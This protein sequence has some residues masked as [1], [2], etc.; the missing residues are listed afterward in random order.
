MSELMSELK[1]A[2]YIFALL[3]SFFTL[4]VGSAVEAAPRNGR[5]VE[6]AGSIER[7]GN[8]TDIRQRSDFLATRWDNFNIAAHESVQAHQPSSTSR[9]LIR[10]DGG[11]ATNIAG[12]YTSNG[13]TILENQ[14]GIQFSRGAIVNVGGLLATSSRISGVSGANWQLNGV[15][16]AVVNHGK[17]VAGAGGA[18]LAAV[19]VQNTGDIT[20]KGGDVALGAGSSFTVDFAG[21]MVGFEVTKAASGVSIVNTGKIESQGGVV[22]LSAQEAQAVRTNVV[23]VGGVVK[24]TKME[25]RGG[26]V[27]LSGGDEGVA[28]VSG[29]VQADE[30]IQMT[31]EYVV[32]KEDAVLTAPEI[33]VGGDFQGKGDVPTA[34]RTLVEA[35]ALLDAGQNGRIIVWS[36][37]TTWFNGRIF[38]PEGFAEVSGKEVLASVNLAGID[39][40]ELLL[41]PEHIG[42]TDSAFFINA[43]VTGNV[44]ADAPTPGGVPTLW[45]DVASVNRFTGNLSLEA[46]TSFSVSFGVTINKPV[47]NLTLIA[48]GDMRI[49]GSINNHA[50]TLTLI[51]GVRLGGEILGFS[52][53][54]TLTASTV[55]LMQNGA[56]SQNAQFTFAADTLSL[57]IT[58][59]AQTVQDWMTSGNRALSLTASGTITINSDVNTGTGALSLTAGEGSETGNLVAC[60]T[61]TLTAGTLALTQADAFGS[62]APFIFD[63]DTL[64]LTTT[65]AAQ[66]V[67]GWMAASGRNLS[68]ISNAA[69]TINE[70]ISIGSGNLT[71][72]GREGIVLGGSVILTAKEVELIG[73]MNTSIDNSDLTITALS[74]VSIHDDINLGNTNNVLTL[75]GDTLGVMGFGKPTLTARTVSLRQNKTFGQ[76]SMF[77]F[78]AS[79]TGLLLTTGDDQKVENWMTSGNRAL[80][81]NA[82]GKITIGGNIDTGAGDLT[83]NGG[84][85]TLSATTFLDGGD[86]EIIGPMSGRY[87]FLVTALGKL[88]MSDNVNLIEGTLN[89]S[90][91]TKIVGVG[92]PELTANLVALTQGETF[93]SSAPFVLTALDTQALRGVTLLRLKTVSTQ[94]VHDWMILEGRDFSLTSTEGAITIGI[95]IA[96]GAGGDLT[97]NGNQGINLIGT[98]P[99]ALS[100]V[101]IS[102]TGLLNAENRA[103]SITAAGDLT[104]NDSIVGESSLNLTGS[105]ILLGDDIS[106]TG[107]AVRLTGAINESGTKGNDNLTITASGRLTLN[108]HINL[109][110]GTLTLSVGERISV[111]N[112]GTSITAA[113]AMIA[114]SHSGVNNREVGFTADG[115]AT[116]GNVNFSTTVTYTFFLV[117]AGVIAGSS[118]VDCS[119]GEGVCLLTKQ[120]EPLATNDGSLASD[121][122][123]TIDLG[124][125]TLTFGGEGAITI[126]APIVSITAGIIDIGDRALTITATSGDLTLNTDIAGTGSGAV[127]LASENGNLILGAGVQFTLP[128]RPLVLTAGGVFSFLRVPET[129]VSDITALSIELSGPNLPASMPS[130]T[131]ITFSPTP[132][133]STAIGVIP[134]W[135]ANGVRP[136]TSTDCAG[137]P[138]ICS[139][140]RADES[141]EI[142]FTTLAPTTSLTIDI[143]NGTLTFGGTGLIMMMSP[144]VSISAGMIDLKGRDLTI[145]ADGNAL[146]LN[147][148]ADIADGGIVMIGAADKA[149]TF[150]ISSARALAAGTISF[151]SSGSSITVGAALSL[152]A[153]SALTLSS[154]LT[155]SGNLTLGTGT[156]TVIRLVAMALV[157]I[158]AD[159]TLAINGAM[160]TNLILMENG[161]ASALSGLALRATGSSGRVELNSDIDIRLLD[162][163]TDQGLAIISSGTVVLSGARRTIAHMGAITLTG[164]LTA[165]NTGL[166]L[167]AGGDITLNGDINLGGGALVLTAG[168]G[169]GTG[170][171]MNGGGA[172]TLTARAVSLTQTSAFPDGALFMLVSAASLT[173]TTA[174]AQ[175]VYNWMV[176]TDRTLSLAAGGD[177]MIGGSVNVGSGSITLAAAGSNILMGAAITLTGADIALTG[178]IDESASGNVGDDV[179]TITAS[180]DITINSNINLGAGALTLDSDANIVLGADITLTGGDVGLTGAMDVSA[181]S[182]SL[183]IHAADDIT[184]NDSINLGAGVLTLAAS[185]IMAV[186]GLT[187]TASAV[188]LMQDDAFSSDPLFTFGSSVDALHLTTDAAQTVHNGWMVVMN[189]DLSLTSTGAL[190]IGADIE[191]GAGDL[192]LGGARIVLGGATTLTGGAITLTGTIDES[193]SGNDALTV[194]AL[195]VLTLNNNIN[196][197][198]GDIT[199]DSDANIVLG[200][201]IRLTG[202]AVSLT[203]AVSAID[204]P[205]T[206]RAQ[207]LTLNSDHINLGTGKLDFQVSSGRI[208]KSGTPLVI[209]AGWLRLAQRGAFVDNELLDPASRVADRVQ[210]LIYD[211]GVTQTVHP[212]MMSLG[213]DAASSL[214]LRGRD[215][216]LDDII[217]PESMTFT[218]SVNLVALEVEFRG[219]LTA[220]E[221]I[222]TTNEIF[223]PNASHDVLELNALAGEIITD[224]IIF[225]D[226]N[227]VLGI[228]G[229]G[230]PILARGFA[231]TTLNLQQDS[232]FGELASLPFEFHPARP[233]TALTMLRLNT[234]AA[235]PLRDWILPQEGAMR[236]LTITKPGFSC[237]TSATG[238]SCI[239]RAP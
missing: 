39:V 152:N 180:G 6:G 138:A 154:G 4:A 93:S 158:A 104:L 84:N 38:A 91:G 45:L 191:T 62:G 194:M 102:L 80:A 182:H 181:A 33:L 155:G 8:H 75:R 5:V 197:G 133:G 162:G 159:G 237:N 119:S 177:I 179:L 173:L 144:S 235:Q 105:K 17:I 72:T 193:S 148:G 44:L 157:D 11:G 71:L 230:R 64:N 110:S 210:L 215:V 128:A 234:A 124:S 31:G 43:Q 166:T 129:P 81:L 9:L 224:N 140:Q 18:I 198:T 69:I 142:T 97:L 21:S 109:G 111:P 196:T 122:S 108:S 103:I 147:L 116:L 87:S 189:R 190:T 73:A 58:N 34:R 236:D 211:T 100:G 127:N 74:F 118:F 26:V 13:I 239:D 12:S 28:E 163:Q 203:G 200:A 174:A 168:E 51:A 130:S 89:L 199:L 96:T 94:I 186:G 161:V 195:D 36:D 65:N 53:T 135:F 77:N 220:R 117:Q 22:A 14:N 35:G 201:D 212:W 106:L 10:V 221:I 185:N 48:G 57:T 95:N 70:N 85:I 169:L 126:T 99:I 27:Y 213:A 178:A 24:A 25:R 23:S 232:A 37:E 107:G 176:V 151:L 156:A 49:S 225:S 121:V 153:R 188:N 55:S 15:G 165:A 172:R 231:I 137:Q 141:L 67:Q 202:G 90:A 78:A 83:L 175:R 60:Q 229:G 54:H 143:G 171:I 61:C 20:S 66:T 192:T 68:L 183:T 19:Q 16:G 32:V 40:G 1:I 101:R 145:T 98:A 42:I 134:S 46:N 123:I 59:A 132:S 167:T 233:A 228:R 160:L 125:G 214:I 238:R 149:L 113:A 30:K 204:L 131:V 217:L 208:T 150:N 206:V 112:S 187:L 82:S 114:F 209:T 56:F 115:I 146:T 76:N 223:P 205:L 29:D 227:D 222:F 226:D 52:G 207:S 219:A 170:D 86:I 139:I 2:R 3:V 47:G 136:A 7:S 50:N 41:D 218:G 92:K 120:D 79:V 63:A 184:I 164:D 216:R 88:E